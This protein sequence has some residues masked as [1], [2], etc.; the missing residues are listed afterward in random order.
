MQFVLDLLPLSIWVYI[1]AGFIGGNLAGEVSRHLN[2]GWLANSV[3]G[4]LGGLIGGHLMAAH[5]AAYGLDLRN[6]VDL[7]D[8]YAIFP[9]ISGGGIGGAVAVLVVSIAALPFRTQSD[10]RAANA[11]PSEE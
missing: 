9:E 6:R 10:N 7:L 3:I 5:G 4:I 2:V 11:Q 8:H 1:G